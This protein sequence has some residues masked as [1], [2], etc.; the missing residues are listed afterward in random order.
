MKAE[1]CPDCGT[2]HDEWIDEDG[3]L[4]NPPPYV[5]EDYSCP[6]CEG[7]DKVQTQM[8]EAKK[9]TSG[10]KLH[11]ARFDPLLDLDDGLDEDWL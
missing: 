5:V 3:R 10:K 7:I 4:I 11:L 2:F 8:R 6:G 1:A 9:D